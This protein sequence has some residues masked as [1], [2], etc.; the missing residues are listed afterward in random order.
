MERYCFLL[1]PRS[2]ILPGCGLNLRLEDHK[3]IAYLP[4]ATARSSISLIALP[5]PVLLSSTIKP[6]LLLEALCKVEQGWD[7]QGLTGTWL[8]IMGEKR[9]M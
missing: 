5:P 3:E 1:Q 6:R 4:P 9:F 7:P 8:R 2:R